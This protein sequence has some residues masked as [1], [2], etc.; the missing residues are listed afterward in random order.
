MSLELRFV[1]LKLRDNSDRCLKTV[2]NI[3]KN[4]KIII[5]Y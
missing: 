1:L 3:F 4:V 5:F 2:K